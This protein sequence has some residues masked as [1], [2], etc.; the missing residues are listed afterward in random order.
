MMAQRQPALFLGHGSPMN[1][2]TE[3]NDQRVWRSLAAAFPRPH[4]ILA[5]SAHWETRG[6]SVTTAGRPETIHDFSG[7]PEELYAVQYPAP[8]DPALAQRVIDLVATVPVQPDP[9]RGFDHGVWSVLRAMYPDADVPVVQLSLD[10]TK[11]GS[12]HYGVGKQ[13]APLRDEGVM[14]LGTGNI[15]H[16]LGAWKPGAP[17]AEWA[18][19][20]DAE[21]RRRLR[22]REHA[23][24]VAHESLGNDAR[25]AVPTP[26]HYLPLLYI[27]ATQRLGEP[28][29]ILNARIEGGISMTS[30]VVGDVSLD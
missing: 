24:L 13:L 21:V 3:T 18:V 11:P 7:F 28:L 29:T 17:P 14:I 15:V 25:Q 10:T 1:A 5:I 26:E 2:I 8:G 4:A 22:E 6:V 30:C 12:Y 23:T 27:V 9:S 16:N 20:F 19:R